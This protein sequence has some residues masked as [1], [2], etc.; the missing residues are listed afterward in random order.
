MCNKVRLL[1]HLEAE[2]AAGGELN[3]LPFPEEELQRIAALARQIG[4]TRLADLTGLDRLGCPIVQA[5][6]P[7]SRSNTRSQG[8]GKSLIRAACSAVMEASEAWAAEHATPTLSNATYL[9]LPD[10]SRRSLLRLDTLAVAA[11]WREQ[12]LDWIAAQDLSNGFDTVLPI[13]L[14][15]TDYRVR[16][17][18]LGAVFAETTTG[19]GAGYS[20]HQACLQALLE[21][22]ERDALTRARRTHGF[23]DRCRIDLRSADG[24]LRHLLDNLES[25]H[26]ILAAWYAPAHLP[27]PVIWSWIWESNGPGRLL[28]FAA[29]GMACA[30][31]PSEAV[32]RAFLE[33]AQ[34]R[35]TAIAGA[36]EDLTRQLYRL[37]SPNEEV[38]LC[39]I[40][41][42]ILPRLNLD[43]LPALR[44]PS[45]LDALRCVMDLLEQSNV[46]PAQAVVLARPQEHGVAVV[47]IVVPGLESLPG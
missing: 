18:S 26:C 15:S 8:K 6:R 40:M 2:R 23:L 29:E 44:P 19:L 1:E 22:I 36:R 37:A 46:G 28:P 12:P 42:G 38:R 21:C 7:K 39:A 30:L 20:F 25:Q 32:L 5:V 41:T 43:Q 4:V 34:A 24:E 13:A 14:V 9:E 33:A 31:D 10:T 27:I 3:A 17:P 35:A 11:D 45:Q 16:D 47:R